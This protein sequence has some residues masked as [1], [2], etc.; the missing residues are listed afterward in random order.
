MLMPSKATSTIFIGVIVIFFLFT[1]SDHTVKATPS[2]GSIAINVRQ[3]ETNGTT[4][5]NVASSTDYVADT[6]CN[7]WFCSWGDHSLWAGSVMIRSVAFWE[8]SRR[9]S[10]NCHAVNVSGG[11]YDTTS[12]YQ[13]G[14]TDQ[15]FKAGSAVNLHS[16]KPLSI[17]GGVPN[18]HV[19]YNNDYVYTDYTSTQQIYTRDHASTQTWQ[20]MLHSMYDNRFTGSCGIAPKLSPQLVLHQ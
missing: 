13:S 20:Q 17:V 19:D 16:S 14:Q 12:S 9:W 8:M 4:Y 1:S 10:S 11:Y 18:W 15:R 7:E 6:L 2:F 3:I 5:W